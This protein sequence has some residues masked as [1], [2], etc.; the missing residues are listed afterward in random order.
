MGA[1]AGQRSD[2]ASARYAA[3][4]GWRGLCA[5]MVALAHVDMLGHFFAWPLVRNGHF[6]VDFFF[7]LSG[8]VIAHAYGDALTTRSDVLRYAIRRFGRLW[9]LH[10]V[11][12]AVFVLAEGGLSLVQAFGLK[13]ANRPPF[14]DPNT[15]SA[16]IS[17]VLL[18]HALGVHDQPTWNL[19][20]WSISTELYVNFLFAVM[21]AVLGRR[22]LVGALIACAGSLLVLG[23]YSPHYIKTVVGLA[24]ARCILGFFAGYLAYR[25]WQASARLRLPW[26][27]VAE[28]GTALGVGVFVSLAGSGP[29]SLLAPFVFLAAVWVFAFEAGPLSRLLTTRPLQF[30]GELSYSIYMVHLIIVVGIAIAAK[31]LVR[32]TGV[33]VFVD[34]TLAEASQ[35]VISF[36]HPL[37]MDLMALIYLGVVI[38]VSALTYRYVE[39]P[40]RRYFNGLSNR[41][42]GGRRTA[43]TNERLA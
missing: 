25:I 7:V 19:P 33:N 21:A 43:P 9:P 16:I 35:K 39:I 23:L 31:L 28:V 8:F 20:S 3:L 18:I 1:S 13:L 38:G 10:V 36:G 22:L 40:A 32:V 12:L 4:D 34:V 37:L 15:P 5:L 27:T 41:F 30:I 26:P 17:N 6:W 29:Y 14:T 42:G 24:V 2:G 11:M